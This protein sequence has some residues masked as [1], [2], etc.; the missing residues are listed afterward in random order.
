MLKPGLLFIVVSLLYLC[1]VVRFLFHLLHLQRRKALLHR[2]R[3]P[4]CIPLCEV[5]SLMGTGDLLLVRG[6]DQAPVVR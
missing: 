1:V 4:P 6:S 3:L 5:L 2:R